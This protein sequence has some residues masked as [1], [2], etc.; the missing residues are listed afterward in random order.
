MP[1]PII[2]GLCTPKMFFLI[3]VFSLYSVQ[4]FGIFSNVMLGYG[5]N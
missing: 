1:S 2:I 4:V 3:C 5:I